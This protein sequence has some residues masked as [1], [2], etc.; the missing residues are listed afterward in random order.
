MSRLNHQQSQLERVQEL[1]REVGRLKA[2]LLNR[3]GYLLRGGG[4]PEGNVAAPV[5]T[6]FLRTDGGTSTT[7]YVKQSGT[8][9]SGW[10]AK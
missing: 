6:L 8:G 1:E 5:G 7:L 9:V 4:S 3:T 10:V 2:L